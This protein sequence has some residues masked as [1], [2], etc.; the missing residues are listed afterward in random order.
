MV[1]SLEV[2]V[3][4]HD[5]KLNYFKEYLTAKNDPQSK[6]KRRFYSK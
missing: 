3:L 2:R 6:D 4:G 1:D 5:A